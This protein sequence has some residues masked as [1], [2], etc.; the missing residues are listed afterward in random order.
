MTEN[1]LNEYGELPIVYAGGVM[2]NSIIR[3][4]LSGEFNCYFAK[5]EFSSDNAAGAAILAYEKEKINGCR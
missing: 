5:P 1:V 3:E 4:S 2:C